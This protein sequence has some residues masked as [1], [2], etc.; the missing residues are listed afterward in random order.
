MLNNQQPQPVVHH[1]NGNIQLHSIFP[2]IQGEGPYT[3]VPAIFV[4]LAGCNLQCPFCD[5]QYTPAETIVTPNELMEM[6]LEQMRLYSPGAYLVVI[7]GGE[8]FR[9][10]LKPFVDEV[11]DFG[12]AVQIETNGTLWQPLD[13]EKITIVCSPKTAKLSKSLIPH[14]SSYKYVIRA[15]DESEEDSLP[16]GVLGLP[17]KNQVAR[18]PKDFPLLQIY[19]QPADEGDPI[20]NKANLDLSIKIAKMHGYTLGIQLHKFINL[21]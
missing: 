12:L 4:R 15:G 8:P 6:V 13:Y 17:V 19:I 7:T 20:K 14:I 16:S 2:T 5:T 11:L 18:P 10:N 3:G 9:Q 21:P 1:P